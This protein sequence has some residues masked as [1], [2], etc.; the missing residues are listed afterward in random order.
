MTEEFRISL[1]PEAPD[2]LGD[3]ITLGDAVAAVVEKCARRT[4][5]RWQEGHDRHNEAGA[6]HTSNSWSLS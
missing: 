6:L 3:W 2:D 1:I 4:G 5:E